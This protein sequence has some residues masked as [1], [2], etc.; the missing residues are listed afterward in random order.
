MKRSD[1]NMSQSE[2]LALTSANLKDDV[3]NSLDNFTIE[4]Q[5]GKGH[6]SVVY[7]GRSLNDGI[8]VALKKV[9]IF[10]MV[11]AKA[12]LECIKEINLLQVN[13]NFLRLFHDGIR[14]KQ[15]KTWFSCP[16]LLIRKLIIYK[17]EYMLLQTPSFIQEWIK[18]KTNLAS[19][20]LIYFNIL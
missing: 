20:F 1:L 7:R 16:P 19:N 15:D 9:Q 2:L 3:F 11:D 8:P 18:L 4:N 17:Y 5:I 6:F 13:N 14:V 12:R 10:D